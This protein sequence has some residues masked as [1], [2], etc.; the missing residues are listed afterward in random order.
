MFLLTGTVFLA[1]IIPIKDHQIFIAGKILSCM[2]EVRSGHWIGV[3]ELME[4][5]TASLDRRLCWF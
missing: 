4:G 3:L 2:L 1:A 5:L